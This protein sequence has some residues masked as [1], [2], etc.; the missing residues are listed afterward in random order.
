[1]E[2][3]FVGQNTGDLEVV[4]DLPGQEGSNADDHVLGVS[5]ERPDGSVETDFPMYTGHLDQPGEAIE[6][7]AL[8]HPRNTL[9]NRPQNENVGGAHIAR[10]GG[11]AIAGAIL[12]GAQLTQPIRVR[13]VDCDDKIAEVTATFLVSQV[14]VDADALRMIEEIPHHECDQGCVCQLEGTTA[15][16]VD[17]INRTRGSLRRFV[18]QRNRDDTGVSGTGVVAEGTLFSDG[19]AIVRWC[20]DNSSIVM[21]NDLDQLLKVHGHGG[22]TRLRWLDT[23]RP[24]HPHPDSPNFPALGR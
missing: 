12:P 14:T 24:S 15:T 7:R 20:G 17:M 11:V 2:R 23:D 10:D 4:E 5:V 1:M 21:W 19:R 8:L 9:P 16:V 18:L 22:A 13:H 6:V 3:D